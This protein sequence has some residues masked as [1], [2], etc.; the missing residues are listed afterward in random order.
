MTR[1]DT[2]IVVV[3]ERERIRVVDV[4]LRDD[5]G[6]TGG[7]ITSEQQRINTIAR[8]ISGHTWWAIHHATGP[9]GTV[10]A[11]AEIGTQTDR[12]HAAEHF[13][14][15]HRMPMPAPGLH[16]PVALIR[17]GLTRD[18]AERIANQVR[19]DTTHPTHTRPA[20]RDTAH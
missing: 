4:D 12:N 16:G 3:I 13:F 11:I 14:T 2:E 7:G 8:A 17:D 9:R 1:K 18:Q 19:A 5:S 15:R 6:L 10:D 20:L